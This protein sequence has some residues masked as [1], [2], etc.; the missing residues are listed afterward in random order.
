MQV[1]RVLDGQGQVTRV[2]QNPEWD[3]RLRKLVQDM[4]DS[5]EMRDAGEYFDLPDDLVMPAGIEPHPV[6]ELAAAGAKIVTLDFQVRAAENDSEDTPTLVFRATDESEDRHGSII[7]FGG[8]DWSWYL[9]TGE[10]VFLYCHDYEFPSIGKTTNITKLIALKA[11]DFTV[12]YAIAAW[13]V[14]NMPNWAELCY[15]LAKDNFMPQVSVGFIPKNAK[16]YTPKTLGIFGSA[17]DGIEFL[18]QEGLELSQVTVGSNRNAYGVKAAIRK[19]VCSE[20]EITASGLGRLLFNSSDVIEISTL[21]ET[22]RALRD[23]ERRAKFVTDLPASAR[24]DPAYPA[25]PAKSRR[26]RRTRRCTGRSTRTS[27]NRS[28]RSRRCRRSS[29][30]TTR[31]STRSCRDSATASTTGSVTCAPTA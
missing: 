8:W 18:E 5:G 15:R 30:T 27:R 16:P 19:G 17:G 13:N 21:P 29:P 9:R 2:E 6:K 31:C 12:E 20:N 28:A 25:E 7:R 14:K 4:V 22:L 11:H 23:P 10:G 1:K 3:A 24:K 26:R